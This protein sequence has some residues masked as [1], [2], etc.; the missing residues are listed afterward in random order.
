MFYPMFFMVLLIAVVGAVTVTRRFASVKD[1]SVK[2]RYF[3]LMSGQDVPE[4]VIQSTRNFNNLFEVP[5]LFFVAGTLYIS[6]G[7]ESSFALACAWFFVIARVAHSYVHLTYNHVM[8]RL[9][10]FALAFAAV[11][12]LWINLLIVME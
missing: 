6:L 9:V 8:H 2:A 1:G 5:I 3:K 7:I 4:L 11:V 10:A 12:A